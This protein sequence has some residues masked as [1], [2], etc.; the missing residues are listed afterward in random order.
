MLFCDSSYSSIPFSATA[1]IGRFNGEII[2]LDLH[3][4]YRP[5]EFHLEL[6]KDIDFNFSK[7]TSLDFHL[8]LEKDSG[9]ILEIEKNI[10]L[11]SV[12]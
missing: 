10:D 2:R 12:R 6:E 5:V 11:L 8:E 3:L 4:Q 9:F 7:C 1:R